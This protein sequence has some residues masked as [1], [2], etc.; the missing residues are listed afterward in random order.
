DAGVSTHRE[1]LETTLSF[2]T[3]MLDYLWAGLPMVVTEGDHFADL[4]DADG[5]GAVVPA[6]DVAALA[7][8]IEGVVYDGPARAA[9]AARVTEA[10]R[11]GG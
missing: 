9:A 2:R 7:S 10:A 1:Q 3:R 4:V 5:L 11:V 6:G 8:A